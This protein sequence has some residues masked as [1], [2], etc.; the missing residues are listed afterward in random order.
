M[1]LRKLATISIILYL[2]LPL[3]TY[4]NSSG[5]AQWSFVSGNAFLPSKEFGN[6]VSIATTDGKTFVIAT[7][8]SIVANCDGN[9]DAQDIT[10]LNINDKYIKTLGRCVGGNYYFGFSTIDGNSY[11]SN[12]L[13]GKSKISIIT[14]TNVKFSFPSSD[15]DSMNNKF[16]GIGNAK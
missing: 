13:H 9:N 3:N 7:A 2:A 12:L 6:K 15:M 1:I 8:N 10:P 11:F 16:L 4:A 5:L 14:G